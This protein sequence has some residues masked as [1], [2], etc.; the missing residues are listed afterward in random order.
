MSLNLL[1]SVDFQSRS[2]CVE[3]V[4]VESPYIRI[5]QLWKPVKYLGNCHYYSMFTW[6]VQAA[7]A[8]FEP[9]FQVCEQGAI[10]ILLLLQDVNCGHQGLS[11]D[12]VDRLG[13][14]AVDFGLRVVNKDIEFEGAHCPILIGF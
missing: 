14:M 10:G 9:N 3:P 13:D 7:L 2:S 11:P 6:A 8:F 1:V 4:Q 5:T 12:P